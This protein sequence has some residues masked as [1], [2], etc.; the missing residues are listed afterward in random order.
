MLWVQSTQKVFW[1]QNGWLA[2]QQSTPHFFQPGMHSIA[3]GMRSTLPKGMPGKLTGAG[4]G[5][6]ESSRRGEDDGLEENTH[7]EDDDAAGELHLVV[8]ELVSL[9]EG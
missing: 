6:S 7:E 2:G 9:I 1:T 3:L 4:G 8:V 5:V